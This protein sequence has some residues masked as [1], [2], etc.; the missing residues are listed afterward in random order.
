MIGKEKI[1]CPF[2]ELNQS[3]GHLPHRL[4]TSLTGLYLR[5][6]FKLHYI[7]HSENCQ[8]QKTYTFMP[9]HPPHI[10]SEIIVDYI[11]PKTL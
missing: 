3:L 10:S 7:S 2:Q 8:T 6:P 9:L 11:P 1:A 4:D 5:S